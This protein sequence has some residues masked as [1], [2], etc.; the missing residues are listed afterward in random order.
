MPDA[1][2]TAGEDHVA[3]AARA[4]PRDHYIGHPRLGAVP[5]ATAQGAIE[6]DLRRAN[7]RP[8]HKILEIGTGTGLTGALLAELTGP[9]GHV[10]SVDI[11]PGLI[12]R[13]HA[14]HAERHVRNITLVTGDGNKG[15]PGHGPF[16]V[17]IAWA[18]PTV[19]P[20]AWLDQAGPGARICA[21]VYY[22]QTTRASAHVRA[23]V[24]A[25]GG[26]DAITLGPASYVD[27]GG[28]V[29]TNFTVPMFYIDAVRSSGG[30]PSWISVAWRGRHPGH[31]PQRALEMLAEPGHREPRPLAPDTAGHRQAWRDFR[32]YCAA[33]DHGSNLTSHGTPD[34][35]NAIGFSSGNNAAVLTDVG[36]ILA[37]TAASPA[38]AK[39][40]DRLDDWENAGRPG[41]STLN[42]TA[43]DK[44]GDLVIRLALPRT[45]HR[46]IRPT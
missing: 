31:D 2:V 45:E 22:A 12:R 15:A 16:D 40:R 24:T 5:Q 38:L 9:S 20:R 34:G 13:A 32:A 10:V 19:I 33:L 8:G 46:K 43:Q 18:T 37:S 4:V 3:R 30:R 25:S 7:V 1:T 6:R 44:D 27:M 21:P 14:L 28:E 41:L 17:I 29:N 36:T 35:G 26:L 39:L 42:A 11:D 23:T